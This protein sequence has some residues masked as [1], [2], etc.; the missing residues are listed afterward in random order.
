MHPAASRV[1][2]LANP[3]A[4]RGMGKLVADAVASKLAD[5]AIDT[6]RSLDH[7]SRAEVDATVDVVVVIGGDGTLRCAVDRLIKTR[8]L[9]QMPRV[10]PVPLGTA[11]LMSQHL[12]LDRSLLHIAAEG[13]RQ[14]AAD[15]LST[16]RFGTN[17]LRVS[18]RSLLPGRR[19]L[20]HR[21]ARHVVTAIDRRVARQID[22]AQLA[23][24]NV[25][26][27]MAGVGFD[28]QVVAELDRH[29]TG[30]IGLASYAR[31]AVAAL[32]GGMFPKLHV[33][34]DGREVFAER[35]IVVIA[36]TPEYGTGFPIAKAALSDDGLLD[37]VCIP[38]RHVGELVQL[39]TRVAAGWHHRSSDVLV[40]R[41]TSVEVT[42]DEKTP[43]QID[44]DPGGTLPL[45]VDVLPA[46]VPF[47]PCNWR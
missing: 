3:R 7:P 20:A 12:G 46:A 26:L 29:R 36:N 21:V 17:L 19:R 33:V 37:V 44:G 8:P 14:V 11:N 43:V 25:F 13:S 41:A 31:P 42:S 45:K 40:T 30:P 4:G 28:A 16:G 10:L 5:R 9:D 27:L 39:M 2:I 34:A 24:G 15:L 35:G 22:V 6:S 1:A 23:D 18:R 47:V 38:C 32:I